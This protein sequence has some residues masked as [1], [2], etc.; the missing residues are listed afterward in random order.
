MIDNTLLETSTEL[1]R[2]QMELGEDDKLN[3]IDIEDYQQT[4]KSYLGDGKIELPWS[5]P[6][7]KSFMGRVVNFKSDR[8][9]YPNSQK[10]KENDRTKAAIIRINSPR[11]STFF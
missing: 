9:I 10:N 2:N 6:K 1:L 3:S 8:A 7:G 4:V 11:G 5:M